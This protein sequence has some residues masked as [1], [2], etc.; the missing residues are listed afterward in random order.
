MRP[1]KGSLKNRNSIIRDIALD[2]AEKVG[3]LFADAIMSCQ[4]AEHA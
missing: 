1:I 2:A 3:Q 4:I